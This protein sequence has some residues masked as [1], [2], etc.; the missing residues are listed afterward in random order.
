MIEE[1]TNQMTDKIRISD[2]SIANL[3]VHKLIVS[4]G[5][6]SHAVIDEL[7]SDDYFIE[8]LKVRLSE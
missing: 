1:I 2:A 4:G 7:V 5:R 3:A 6:F 8:Q